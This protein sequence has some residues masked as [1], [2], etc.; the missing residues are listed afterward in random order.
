MKI[1]IGNSKGVYRTDMYEG[2]RKGAKLGDL[3]D[4]R[5]TSM[6]KRSKKE[7]NK[8]TSEVKRRPHRDLIIFETCPGLEFHVGSIEALRHGESRTFYLIK[9]VCVCVCVYNIYIHFRPFYYFD[10]SVQ[11]GSHKLGCVFSFFFFLRL[12]SCVIDYRPQL[13]FFLPQTDT[14]FWCVAAFFFHF[15]IVEIIFYFD[16]NVNR[17]ANTS[18][19]AQQKTV[20]LFYPSRR[21]IQMK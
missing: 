17:R 12:K 16:L 13:F 2:R 21:N 18:C 5:L 10:L 15:E 11:V 4:A 19:Q 3:F 20:T 8:E 1:A 6:N 9:L 14:V 7:R